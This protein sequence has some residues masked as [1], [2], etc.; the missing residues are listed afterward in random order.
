MVDEVFDVQGIFAT[1]DVTVNIP[2]F[3]KMD[4]DRKIVSQTVHIERIIGLAKTY[5]ILERPLND[6]ET[7]LGNRIVYCCFTLC[8]MRPCIV[9]S[10]A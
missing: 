9:P 8:N 4:R 3:L 5:E 2:T 1:K 10:D 7:V 6:T